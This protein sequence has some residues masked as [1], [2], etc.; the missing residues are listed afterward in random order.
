MATT[1]KK[2]KKLTKVYNYIRDFGPVQSKVIRENFKEKEGWPRQSV[3]EYLKNLF[4]RGETVKVDPIALGI[5]DTRL[6]FYAASILGAN[7][8]THE[9]E[10][11]QEGN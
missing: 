8:S 9:E 3:S 6:A 5:P 10:A 11:T 7:I 1:K 2:E 4:E